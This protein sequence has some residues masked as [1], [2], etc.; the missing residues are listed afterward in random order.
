MGSSDTASDSLV[1]Y[2]VGAGEGKNVGAREG[3]IDGAMLG[4]KEGVSVGC[5]V[6]G[7]VAAMVGTREGSKVGCSVGASVGG[8]DSVGAKLGKSVLSTIASVGTSDGLCVTG[9]GKTG[10]SV[11]GR[12]GNIDG[13]CITK[14]HQ[15]ASRGRGVRSKSSR[16]AGLSKAKRQRV[17]LCWRF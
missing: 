5:S 2:S 14:R 15:E 8:T 11:G 13:C 17:H 3:N 6:G 10:V 7:M 4:V 12:E 9:S 1:G 16:L